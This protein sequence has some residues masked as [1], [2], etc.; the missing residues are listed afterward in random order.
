MLETP[1][2]PLDASEDR[3]QWNLAAIVEWAGLCVFPFELFADCLIVD[4][5]CTALC[6]I[7]IQRFETLLFVL[8]VCWGS[9]K[10]LHGFH[11]EELM[12][13]VVVPQEIRRQFARSFELSVLSDYGLDLFDK[14]V[15]GVVTGNFEGSVV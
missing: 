8:R 13:V 1:K 2:V 5:K 3:V 12:N 4:G 6:N 11:V 14:C 7:L 9:D 10:F 15:L